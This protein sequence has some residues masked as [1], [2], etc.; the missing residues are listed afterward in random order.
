VSA[1]SRRHWPALDGVRAL[2]VGSVMLYHLF[3][4]HLLP[5]GFLGVDVFFVLSGFL[6]TWGLVEERD[7]TARV[8]LRRF[9]ARRALRLLPALVAVVA[10]AVGLAETVLPT[11]LR[12]QT[13]SGLPWIALYA[14]NWARALGVG[15]LGVLPHLWSL[16]VEE[17]F[18]FLWPLVVVVLTRFGLRRR[19]V[20]G[21]L[22]VLALAETGY[23]EYLFHH[24]APTARIAFGLDT[25]SD[26]LMLGSAVALLLSAG[27]LERVP[28]A[29]W[30]VGAWTALAAIGVLAETGNGTSSFQWSYPL[31]A[32][33]TAVL[34]G[35]LA[36][37]GRSALSRLLASRLPVWVGRRSYGLY[38]WSY[39]V[40][41]GL[42]WPAG[43]TGVRRDLSEIAAS[44]VVAALS[45]RVVELP[46]L[47]R[48]S[49][50]HALGPSGARR[51]RG[52]PALAR[53]PATWGGGADATTAEPARA[54]AAAALAGRHRPPA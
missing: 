42:P 8:S 26:G 30:Q 7:R 21:A 16:A 28:R 39:L 5:S 14:G 20:A 46:F 37:S 25:H 41:Y 45:Y 13:L 10:L 4:P 52:V 47:R 43:F 36:T 40:Y 22:V 38:L 27:A 11:A 29:L 23:R 2:A 48:K 12:R 31:T 3:E 32:W 19:V 9:Y 54:A 24:G 15:T 44:V 53:P 17:Q 6:I 33:A 49:R 51:R 18:Y 50:L 34:V 1:G 35:A